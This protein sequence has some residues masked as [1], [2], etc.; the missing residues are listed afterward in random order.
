MKIIGLRIEKY[1]GE[2]VTGHNCDFEY[3]KA[4]MDRHVLLCINDWG[5]KVEITLKEEQGVCGS[6]WIT[7]SW[8]L[9]EVKRVD[10]FNG[11]NYSPIKPL[12]IPNIPFNTEEVSNSVFAVD[13]DGGDGYYPSGSYTIN[14]DLF[15]PTLRGMDLRPTYIFEGSSNLGK[16]TLARKTEDLIVYETDSS[17]TLPELIRA[18]IIVKGNKYNHTTEDIIT[19]CP[20]NTKVILCAF[21]EV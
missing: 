17:E 13:Q 19:A 16:S 7:A 2:E 11:Y 20:D 5:Q 6:G 3:T 4:E 10:K 14:M 12:E 1:I 9:M 15:K 8:G 18:D 21:T